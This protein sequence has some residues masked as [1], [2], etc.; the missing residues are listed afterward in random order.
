LEPILVLLN[1]ESGY[2]K[3][4][5]LRGLNLNVYKSE[6]MAV[7]GH[8]GAGKTTLLKTMFRLIPLQ[9][10]VMWYMGKNITRTPTSENQK[11]R[12]SF[13]P[14]DRAVFPNLTVRENIDLS[15]YFSHRKGDKK[16]NA[17]E[18][19]LNLFP[20]LSDR[21][22]SKALTL[23]GG[24]KQMLAVGMALSQRPSL[25]LLDEPSLG[26]GPIIVQNLMKV[27]KTFAEIYSTSVI[28]VEQ[29][30]KEALNVSQRVCVMKMGDIVYD[31][32]V[33]GSLDS[34]AIIKMF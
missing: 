5:I 25:L 28:L 32:S 19:V 24:L 31:E 15:F 33:A 2:H 23:S 27:I 34:G 11:L 16:E 1:V 30:I 13:V 21:L 9:N 14:Q 7:I 20:A 17:M 18:E 3:K 26:L 29:N 6:V 12:I 10:G 8:N 4:N 22:A